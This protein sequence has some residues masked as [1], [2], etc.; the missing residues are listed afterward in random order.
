[1][2]YC[3]NNVEVT[4]P[5]IAII[6]GVTLTLGR[7]SKEWLISVISVKSIQRGQLENSTG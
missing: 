3:V 2:R 6:A 1:M 4:N 5:Y 7:E